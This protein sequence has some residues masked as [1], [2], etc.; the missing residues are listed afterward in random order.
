M[1][2]ATEVAERVT[3]ALAGGEPL[4]AIRI[5]D[6]ESRLLGWPEFTPRWVL[7]KSLN[8]WFGHTQIAGEDLAG[9]AEELRAATAAADI[10]GVPSRKQAQMAKGWANVGRY[11]AHYELANGATLADC[12]FHWH[13]LEQDLFPS[14]FEAA[15][16]LKLIT[17]RDV[18][19][20]L[21]RTFGLNHV[22]AWYPI[23]EEANTGR[24]ATIHYPERFEELRRELVRFDLT[25]TL[26]LVGAGALG[27]IYCEWVKRAG[28]VAL[29]IGSVFD[30]WAGVPSRSGMHADPERHKL[31]EVD[32][33][34]LYE[35]R[36]RARTDIAAHLPKLYNLVTSMRAQQVIELGVRGGESTIAFLA[37]LQKTDGLPVRR[38]QTGRLWSC[39]VAPL[40]LPIAQL[41][42]KI[43][44]WEF[45]AGDDRELLDAAPATCD[46]LF[47]DT[48]HEYEHTLWELE[49]YGARVRAGG[50][51]V[52]HDTELPAVREAID[53]YRIGRDSVFFDH[54]GSHG[55]GVLLVDG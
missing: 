21:A 53:A 4:S 55:L 13:L 43:A 31:P 3:E 54:H 35:A 19:E 8:Y 29:D 33:Q 5:G 6:G 17:C 32:L 38:T 23:P 18:A 20:P 34:A 11:L 12:N 14:L 36:R 51:I 2:E 52:L 24:Q 44:H 42:G 41:E 48:S 47:I 49:N 27:K 1:I 25:G 37:A 50:Y 46:V 40:Q 10:L 28:G 45:V 9:L 26:V 39:D 15:R 22:P 30:G 7:D 16:A